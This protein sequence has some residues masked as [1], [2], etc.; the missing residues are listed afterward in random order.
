METV[1]FDNTE[2]LFSLS[3]KKLQLLAPWGHLLIS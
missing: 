3:A 2:Q 1:V